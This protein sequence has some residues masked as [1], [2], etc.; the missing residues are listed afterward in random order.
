MGLG[1]ISQALGETEQALKYYQEAVAVNQKSLLA[2]SY[3]G[4]GY[5]EAD[6]PEAASQ[7]FED[8]LLYDP[9]NSFAHIGLFR[10]Y[11]AYEQPDLTHAS[12]IVEHGQFTWENLIRYLR[13]WEGN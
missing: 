7:V 1:R 2:L 6:N 12:A 5:L 9:T 11:N 4:N 10:A 3:L 8:L 13:T